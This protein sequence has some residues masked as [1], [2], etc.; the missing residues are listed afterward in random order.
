MKSLDTPVLQTFIGFFLSGLI[1]YSMLQH[2][3][4]MDEMELEQK[5]ETESKLHSTDNQSD[6]NLSLE[7]TLAKEILN[8]F[9]FVAFHEYKLR[10]EKKPAL[11]YYLLYNHLKIHLNSMNLRFSLTNYSL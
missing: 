10:L 1:L 3:V 5:I 9:V 11:R 4:I 8:H 2:P 7:L 6:Q